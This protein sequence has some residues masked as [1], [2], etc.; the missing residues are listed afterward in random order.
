MRGKEE[1]FYSARM[2]TT[3]DLTRRIEDHLSRTGESPSSFG[4][5]IAKD[6]NLVRDIRAGREPRL[7]L[8]NRLLEATSAQETA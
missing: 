4:W 1:S 5:R 6:S 8:L 7:G 2:M 3:A